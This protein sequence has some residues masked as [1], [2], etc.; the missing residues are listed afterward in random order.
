M[1]LELKRD[2][3]KRFTQAVAQQLAADVRKQKLL[4]R[5]GEL[6][7]ERVLGD[8]A[9]RI[10]LIVE[11]DCRSR[12]NKREKGG[13][14]PDRI[15][16]E[17]VKRLD[18]CDAVKLGWNERRFF[19]EFAQ[20]RRSSRL[21]GFNGAADGLPGA[22]EVTGVLPAELEKLMTASRALPRDENHDLIGADVHFAAPRRANDCPSIRRTTPLRLRRVKSWRMS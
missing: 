18:R 13:A 8:P 3:K 21:A 6:L 11:G 12:G 14:M 2:A 9:D 4:A 17:V 10:V 22:V 20:R 16:A 15:G 5:P 1:S 19:T 7:I